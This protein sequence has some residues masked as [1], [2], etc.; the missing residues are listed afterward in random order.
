MLWDSGSTTTG[1]TP[2]FAHIAEIKVA[3]LAV[4]ITL[5]LGT[6]GSFSIIDYGAKVTINIPEEYCDIYM[7]IANFD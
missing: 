7:N 5:Q 3:P 6:I 4:S 1:L 2:S